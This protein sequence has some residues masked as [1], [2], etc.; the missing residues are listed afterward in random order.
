MRVNVK[1]VQLHVSAA[2]W[3]EAHESFRE[4][5]RAAL[6]AVRTDLEAATRAQ[7]DRIVIVGA[8]GVDLEVLA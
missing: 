5:V 4:G 8:G 6:R 3:T 2:E 7:L 1:Y